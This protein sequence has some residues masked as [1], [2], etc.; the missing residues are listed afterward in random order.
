MDEKNEQCTER[1]GVDTR[2]DT[3][4]FQKGPERKMDPSTWHVCLR[5]AAVGSVCSASVT[6]KKKL[7]PSQ[8]F[9]GWKSVC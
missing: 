2:V 9:G 3:S 5:D 8:A 1:V 4:V 7:L 6:E